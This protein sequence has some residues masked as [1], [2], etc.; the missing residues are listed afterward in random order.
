MSLVQLCG[1]LDDL[2]G[3]KDAQAKTTKVRNDEELCMKLKVL[4]NDTYSKK[5]QAL[6]LRAHTF[7]ETMIK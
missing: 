1:M 3:D 7:F 4:E 6:T 5:V 2:I